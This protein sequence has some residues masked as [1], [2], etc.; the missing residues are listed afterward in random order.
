MKGQEA[1]AQLEAECLG[2]IC[3]CG[4]H[5]DVHMCTPK[6]ERERE[7]ERER[8][9]ERGREGEE[10]GISSEYVR[11]FEIYISHFP[12]DFRL[13][14]LLQ[15]QKREGPRHSAVFNIFGDLIHNSPVPWSRHS[16]LVRLFLCGFFF[17][18]WIYLGPQGLIRFARRDPKLKL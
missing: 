10:D 11:Y 5:I 12:Y 9:R 4:H 13:F 8:E 6:R 3:V 16:P 18:V 1:I 17:F 15:S 7:K 2:G 14:P